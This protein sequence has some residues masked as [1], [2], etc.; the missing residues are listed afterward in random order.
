MYQ[1][2]VYLWELEQGWIGRHMTDRQTEIINIFQLHW[3]LLT[4]I[5]FFSQCD[6]TISK[7]VKNTV[8]SSKI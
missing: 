5:F 1:S 8:N 4:R 2:K 3:K 6:N 7:V